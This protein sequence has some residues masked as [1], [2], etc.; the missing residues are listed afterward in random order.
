MVIRIERKGLYQEVAD[1]LRD[2]IQKGELQ[3]GEWV[4]EVSLSKSLGISRTPLRE[5]LKV[6]VAEGLLY[7]KPRHGCFV[8]EVTAQDLEDIFPLMAMLEGRCAFE[9]AS[10]VTEADLARLEPLHSELRRYAMQGDVDQYYAANVRIHT[11]IQDLAANRWLS[12]LINNLR[13]VLSLFRHRS[14]KHPGRIDQSYQEHAAIFEAIK[15]RDPVRAE[16]VT[17]TH[18][19]NQLDAL[20][21]LSEQDSVPHSGAIEQPSVVTN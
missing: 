3:P 17:R 10:K 14:L 1:R 4:D 13:Q 16:A 19:M 8:N 7:M 5:A 11:A 21:K 9:A 15:A 20:R 12:D 2:M 18:L 6:L